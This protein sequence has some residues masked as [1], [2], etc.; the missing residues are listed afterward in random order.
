MIGNI[1][2]SQ[3]S[4]VAITTNNSATTTIS[5]KLT[6]ENGNSGYCNMTIPKNAIPYGT[7]P[8]L[9]VDGIR[10]TN[11]GYTQDANSFYIW[12]TTEFSTHEMKIQFTGPQIQ[13]ITFGP[14]LAVGIAIPEI[15]LIYAVIAVR[16]LKRKPENA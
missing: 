5:F 3:I 7:I 4:G 12:F 16:R 1:T 15:V 9:F 11:Q 6:G 10:A 13:S 14:V 2:N 8:V